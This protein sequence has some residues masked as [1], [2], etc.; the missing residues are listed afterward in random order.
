MA[1]P[2]RTARCAQSSRSSRAARHER[3]VA[4]LMRL[5]RSA[6]ALCAFALCAF[7][8]CACRSTSSAATSE[9]V[10]PAGA[11]IVTSV[12]ALLPAP[13]R[14]SA[15]A[16]SPLARVKTPSASPHRCEEV[17]RQARLL[18]AGMP[19][20]LDADTRATRVFATGCDLTLE[21]ELS[22]LSAADV[23]PDG[24]QAMRD[25]ILEVVCVDHGALAVLE[26]GGT[27]TNQY[28][29]RAHVPIGHFTI[30]EQDCDP[31]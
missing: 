28:Y 1:S 18:D 3:S 15:A 4:A 6:F 27:V 16:A 24:V 11:E 21:Y 19:K 14:P 5:G 13:A 2:S 8:L 31:L 9:H 10:A 30:A 22:T 29:D 26:H 20:Q 7:A 23:D 17:E 25:Q 12:Q